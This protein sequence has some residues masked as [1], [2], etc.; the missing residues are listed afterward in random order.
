[1]TSLTETRQFYCTCHIYLFF[2]FKLLQNVLYALFRF[3]SDGWSTSLKSSV[4]IKHVTPGVRFGHASFSEP[5]QSALTRCFFLLC[6]CL[7]FAFHSN[8]PRAPLLLSLIRFTFPSGLVKKRKL[9]DD[10]HAHS[11]MREVALELRRQLR[12]TLQL[13]TVKK[14]WASF[15]YKANE[16]EPE[17]T[18]W[19]VGVLTPFM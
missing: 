16:A 10:I 3:S 14:V 6:C 17:S 15:S 19:C 8:L 9:R 13:Q 11:D 5:C 12:A 1:M 4:C 7:L 18:V 2:F